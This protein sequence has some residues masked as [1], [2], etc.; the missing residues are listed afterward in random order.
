M[1]CQ[2]AGISIVVQTINALKSTKIMRNAMEKTLGVDKH[3]WLPSHATEKFRHSVAKSKDSAVKDEQKPLAKWRF[4][5]I[6]TSTIT[7]LALATIY[8]KC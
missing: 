6:A 5:A 1:H 3:A 4:I 8:L 7:N 2:S